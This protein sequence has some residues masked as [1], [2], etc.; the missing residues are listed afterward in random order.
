MDAIA[1]AYVR[2]IVKGYITIDDVPE[3]IKERVIELLES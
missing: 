1:K 2:R 3:P